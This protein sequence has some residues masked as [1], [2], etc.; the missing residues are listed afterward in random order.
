VPTGSGNRSTTP[1]DP[2]SERSKDVNYDPVT[3]LDF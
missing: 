3:Y 1:F 2:R